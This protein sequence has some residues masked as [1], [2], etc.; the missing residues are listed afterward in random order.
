LF[1][2]PLDRKTPKKAYLL[3]A[4]LTPKSTPELNPSFSIYPFP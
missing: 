3:Y 1:F 4:I 2:L